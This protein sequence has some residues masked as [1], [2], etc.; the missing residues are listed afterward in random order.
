MAFV[1]FC[2]KCMID[3]YEYS[4]QFILICDLYHQVG[5]PIEVGLEEI[6][7]KEGQEFMRVLKKLEYLGCI[8]STETGKNLVSIKPLG[9]DLVPRNAPIRCAGK[10]VWCR[11]KEHTHGGG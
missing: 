2:A 1:Y 11:N 3:I 8:I 5:Q 6:D 7:C 10:P 4:Q 9:F